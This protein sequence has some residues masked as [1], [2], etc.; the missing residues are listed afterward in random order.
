[1]AFCGR[2]LGVALAVG[3]ALPSLALAQDLDVKVVSLTSPVK[4]GGKAKLTVE[5]APKAQCTPNLLSTS[6]GANVGT[7]L[8]G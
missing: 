8:R 2:N 4:V 7:K 1:M 6:G 3:L 5:T